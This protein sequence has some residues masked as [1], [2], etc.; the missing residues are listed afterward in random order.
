MRIFV[1][2]EILPGETRA[3]LVPNSVARLAKL[4]AEVKVE[5]GLGNTIFQSDDLYRD[6]GASIITD[7]NGALGAADMVLRLRKPPAEEVALLKRG[8]IHVS[9][10][11]P[12]N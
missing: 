4:G 8:C 5:S 10:L 2:R 6:A 11:D 3:P 1:P 12:F 9:F 7:R